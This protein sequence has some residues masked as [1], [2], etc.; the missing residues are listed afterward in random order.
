MKLIQYV[1]EKLFK[2]F[3]DVG[4]MFL[5]DE[6]RITPFSILL[7]VF[8]GRLPSELSSLRFRAP[9]SISNECRTFTGN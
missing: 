7:A 3:R 2:Y 4:T 6:I 9:E 1:S 5:V 8:Q